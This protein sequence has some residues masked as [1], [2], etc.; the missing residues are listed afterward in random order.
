MGLRFRKSF[1]LGK[2]LRLNWSL[3]GP[4]LSVGPRGASIS[5]G[6]RG[7]YANIGLPGTGL[8]W[9]QRLDRPAPGSTQ[10]RLPT[11][12]S[13]RVAGVLGRGE[14]YAGGSA[15]QHYPDDDKLI[16][17]TLAW[18]V[19]AAVLLLGITANYVIL[20]ESWPSGTRTAA[21]IDPRLKEIWK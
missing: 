4:S 15:P 7:T 5:V 21:D 6:S 1:G 3:S 8:S 16:M 14:G 19:V 10:T 11:G 12:P 17:R 2:L 13:G 18:I 9:R 20:R